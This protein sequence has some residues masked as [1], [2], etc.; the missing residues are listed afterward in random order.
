MDKTKSL[1]CKYHGG[2][3]NQLFSFLNSYFVSSKYGFN[4]L[5]DES[6]FIKY[7]K[8]KP[9]LYKIINQKIFKKI[10]IFQ[11]LKFRFFCNQVLRDPDISKPFQFSEKLFEKIDMNKNIILDG[12]FQSFEFINKLSLD[13]LKIFLKKDFFDSSNKGLFLN[14]KKNQCAVHLR[15]GDFYNDEKIR[16]IHGLLSNE[17]FLDSIE[18]MHKYKNIEEFVIFSDDINY[19]KDLFKNL[20]YKFKFVE[21]LDESESFKLLTFFKYFIISNS[22]FSLLATFLAHKKKNIDQIIAPFIWFK[23]YSTEDLNLIFDK[24]VFKIFR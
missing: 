9:V 19:V 17:Y 8:F 5:I 13:D 12:Y 21:N 24:K 1:I 23:N 11:S 7:K 6:K 16:K 3:G 20:N 2:L 22:T 14:N 10:N 18:Y 4:L 15:R